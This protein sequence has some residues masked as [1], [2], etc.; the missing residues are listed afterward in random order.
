[1]ASEASPGSSSPTSAEPG[2]HTPRLEAALVHAVTATNGTRDLVVK[3]SMDLLLTT[4]ILLGIL[5][6]LMVIAALIKLTSRGPVLFRQERC[7][8]GG[9][10]FTCL[11]FRSM[12]DGADEKKAEIEHL[13]RLDGPVFKTPEDPRVTRVGRFLR[14][15]SLDELPQLINV[16]RGEMSLVGPRPPIP[17]EVERYEAWQKRRL[18]IKPGITCLWQVEGRSDVAFARWIQLDLWYIDHWSLWLDV[19]ILLKTVPAVLSRK[20]AY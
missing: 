14:R 10:R 7:G 19:K 1:M 20:G 13:N 12:V 11:K 5:P 16:L 2:F 15:W 6:V 18:S 8:L 4:T 17:E 3:R 9:R